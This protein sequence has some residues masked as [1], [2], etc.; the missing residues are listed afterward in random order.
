M[1][2]D[3]D[4]AWDGGYNLSDLGGIPTSRGD[5]VRGRVYRSGA[6][7][8]LTDTGWASARAAGIT[9]VV[10]LRSEPERGRTDAHPPLDPDSLAGVTIVSAPTEDPDDPEFQRVCGPWL[11][12]PRSYAD[13]LAFYPEKFAVVFRAIATADGA[14]LVHCAG[15][16]DRTGMISA[17]L[18]SLA[19]AD[20]EQIADN[21]VAGWRGANADLK[22]HPV[23]GRDP[24]ADDVLEEQVLDRR[25]VLAEW[26]GS[27]S[28][29]AYLEQAGLSEAERARLASILH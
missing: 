27:F 4:P 1:T 24:V 11:D 14:V 17:M 6:H 23:D 22:K 18:L 16:R 13:N 29:D 3:T 7:E 26:I 2:D 12:H 9:T 20:P 8:F 28:V 10:D 21:Y 15:G 19:G 25:P 5:T